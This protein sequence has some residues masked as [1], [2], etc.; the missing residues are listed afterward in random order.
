L[1][2]RK[3]FARIGRISS[4]LFRDVKEVWRRK[5]VFLGTADLLHVACQSFSYLTHREKGDLCFCVASGNSLRPLH[6]K[7]IQSKHNK[8][9]KMKNFIVQKHDE[10]ENAKAIKNFFG[11]QIYARS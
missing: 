3:Q 9:H 2:N 5:S 6:A 8:L 1:R 11:T 7:Q 10:E 4:E